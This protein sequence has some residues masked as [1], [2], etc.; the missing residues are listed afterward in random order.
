MLACRAGNKCFSQ[1]TSIRAGS[2]T[3]LLDCIQPQLSKLHPIHKQFWWWFTLHMG[4]ACQGLVF[5]YVLAPFV[6]HHYS[7]KIATHFQRLRDTSLVFFWSRKCGQKVDMNSR[8][9]ALNRVD[10]TLNCA[11]MFTY[12]PHVQT[13]QN[14]FIKKMFIDIG[15]NLNFNNKQ[16]VYLPFAITV[17]RK[18]Q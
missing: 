4:T 18:D 14:S 10:F 12:I 13:T 8:Y 5:R 2:F 6:S 17:V 9:Y 16:D 3:S 7:T 1:C 15:S 11:L